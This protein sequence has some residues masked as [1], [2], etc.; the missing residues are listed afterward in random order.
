M[1]PDTENVTYTVYSNLYMTLVKRVTKV[2]C[3]K[4]SQFIKKIVLQTLIDN[5]FFFHLSYI[6]RY[7]LV[8]ERGC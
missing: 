8:L 2:W 6:E 7:P 5:S 4:N 1:E 3:Q